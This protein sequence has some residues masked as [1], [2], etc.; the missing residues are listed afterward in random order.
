M[1]KSL[2]LKRRGFVNDV[3]PFE[4]TVSTNF[5]WH[6]TDRRHLADIPRYMMCGEKR[7]QVWMERNKGKIE[8]TF[9]F[10]PLSKSKALVFM[11]CLLIQT[12]CFCLV[13]LTWFQQ[14]LSQSEVLCQEGWA[15]TRKPG[16]SSSDLLAQLFLGQLC[17]AFWGWA[18]FMYS[19]CSSIWL[20]NH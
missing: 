20:V 15:A 19:C 16:M 18:S 8:M 11:P 14:F 12:R 4:G 6:L 1:C 7:A 17:V 2:V 9:I 5:S 10:S 3:T 13:L